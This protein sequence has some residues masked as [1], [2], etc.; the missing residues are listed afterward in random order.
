M[1]QT[2]ELLSG[3]SEEE[4]A[5]Y[6]TMENEPHV[7]INNDRTISVPTEL[8]RIAVQYDKDIE[9]VTF[10]CP[11]YWDNIDLS[12]HVIY[13]NYKRADGVLGSYIAENVAVDVDDEKLIH[14]TWTISSHVS[15]IKG[16]LLFLVCIKDVD[17][18]GNEITHWNS[19]LCKDMHVSEGLECIDVI[20][21]EYPDIITQLIEMVNSNAGSDVDLSDYVQKREGYGLAQLTLDGMGVV[22]PG[23]NPG[24][25][26]KLEVDM[27]EYGVVSADIPT[28]TSHLQ[29]DS[30]FVAEEDV[31]DIKQIIENIE[32]TEN[33]PELLNPNSEYANILTGISAVCEKTI[34]K[35]TYIES[36]TIL[37]DSNTNVD[38]FAIDK[39]TNKCVYHKLCKCNTGENV[40]PIN[41]TTDCD[42]LFGVY[43]KVKYKQSSSIPENNIWSSGHL[44]KTDPLV[45]HVGDSVTMSNMYNG[46]W[47]ISVSFKCKKGLASDVSHLKSQVEDINNRINVIYP[48]SGIVSFIDDDTGKFVPDIW[49]NIISETG[50]RMGFA[51]VTGIMGGEIEHTGVYEPMTLSYLKQLYDE[52]HEVYSHTHSHPACYSD[53]T[54]LDMLDEECRKSRD[55]LNENGFIRNSDV[56]VYSGGLGENQTDKQAVVRRNYKWGIDT[57][58]GGINPEPISN[59][60]CVYRCN[61]DTMTLEELKAKVDVAV[62]ENKLLVLMNHA[63]QLNLDKENQVN[64]IISLINYIKESGALILP[65]EEAVHQIYGW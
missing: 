43:G 25:P 46:N 15:L 30:G 18:G 2:E 41:W 58:G 24:K 54:T 9:T 13:I 4:M 42:C 12:T 3:L 44:V 37:V 10:D 28:C 35:G 49:G 26:Y 21:D 31:D 8:K 48:H 33:V 23:V 38:V 20:T 57:V 14:F 11:R 17:D 27:R 34:E 59:P 39:T 29:N 65:F 50:I 40:I 45:P 19:E 60:L 62:S 64:K 53:S 63:Y 52:G 7:V 47:A 1:S 32:T 16:Q 6:T 61:A 36:A 22:V 5:V 56:I 51:C 55:W